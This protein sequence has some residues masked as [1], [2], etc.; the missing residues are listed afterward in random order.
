M[1]NVATHSLARSLVLYLLK[2]RRVSSSKSKSI[3]QQRCP[4]TYRGPPSPSYLKLL[5]EAR[6]C[7]RCLKR[8]QVML[9]FQMRTLTITG[10][11]FIQIFIYS[12]IKCSNTRSL[13]C[14]VF[15]S[16]SFHLICLF[17]SI[18][19]I[20][21]WSGIMV[22]VLHNIAPLL[23]NF[24]V[25]TFP[26]PNELL[27]V[28]LRFLR[29]NSAQM[30]LMHCSVFW[31]ECLCWKVTEHWFQAECV[32]GCTLRGGQWDEQSVQAAGKDWMLA[33][34]IRSVH[35]TAPSILSAVKK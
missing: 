20:T 31:K 7:L 11:I 26:S 6:G 10:Q 30:L 28:L 16:K 18:F 21:A 25:F 14:L 3:I 27:I 19:W 13:S 34:I 5:S 15:K 12:N 29:T 23:S 2:G 24:V 35:D 33:I 17:L 4:W 32:P 1:K 22:P 8:T 9:W